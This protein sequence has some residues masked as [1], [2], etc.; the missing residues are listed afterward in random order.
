M[1]YFLDRYVAEQA[2]MLARPMIELAFSSVT[3]RA[4]LHI[5]VVDPSCQEFQILHEYTFGDPTRWER[6]YHVFARKKALLTHRTRQPSDVVQCS[7]HLLS[8]GDVLYGGSAIL[9]GVIVG[10]SGVEAYF[11]KMFAQ[12]VAAACIGMAAHTKASEPDHT[13]EGFLPRYA[14]RRGDDSQYPRVDEAYIRAWIARSASVDWVSEHGRLS[15][16]AIQHVERL[17]HG[18]VG[19]VLEDVYQWSLEA[20]QRRLAL[21]EG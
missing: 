19:I 14:T 20:A 1:S 7:P 11:D 16:E 4:D 3:K 8:I 9:E 10:V 6:P 18:S 21:P 2:V 17:A 12:V 15:S 5:V 13:L